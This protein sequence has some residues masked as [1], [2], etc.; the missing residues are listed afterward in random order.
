MSW[1]RDVDTSTPMACRSQRFSAPPFPRV[2]KSLFFLFSYRNAATMHASLSFRVGGEKKKGA[3]CQTANNASLQ[4]CNTE[5]SAEHQSSSSPSYWQHIKI[6]SFLWLTNFA[7]ETPQPCNEQE[8][9]NVVSE[10]GIQQKQNKRAQE[11]WDIRRSGTMSGTLAH[12]L[13]LMKMK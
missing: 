11:D 8:T 5:R 1:F 3:Q 12:F 13:S 6:A 9:S 2:Y 4:G 7:L 10:H